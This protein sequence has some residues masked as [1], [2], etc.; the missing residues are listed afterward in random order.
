MKFL[1][2]ILTYKIFNTKLDLKVSFKETVWNQLIISICYD[3]CIYS[4]S[5]KTIFYKKVFKI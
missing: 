4:Q 2:K 3:L 1:L 5:L